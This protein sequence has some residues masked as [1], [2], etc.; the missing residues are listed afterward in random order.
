M[1]V[2]RPFAAA[3]LLAAFAL[4]PAA[5]AATT[6]PPA[7]LELTVDHSTI[8]TQARHGF[9]FRS[10]IRNPGPAAEGLVA[11]PNV[12]SLRAQPYVDPED[13]SSQRVVFL[14]PIPAGGSLTLQW[15]M[16]A[17]NSGILGVYVTVLD[18]NPGTRSAQNAPTIVVRVTERRT[19]NPSGILPLAIARPALLGAVVIWLRLH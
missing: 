7:G 18:K 1:M 10:T 6:S 16:T 13:W 17:V 4:V 9:D 3:A 5:A 15:P 19:V 8:S 12:L 2:P 14:D 11:H